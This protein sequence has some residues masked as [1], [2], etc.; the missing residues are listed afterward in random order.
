MARQRDGE[1]S[2]LLIAEPPL[3]VLPSLATLVGLNEAIF[4]QQLHYWLLQSGKDR[5]GRK[6]V[7]NT[8]EEWHEQ[9]PFWSVRTIRRIV[10]GLEEQGLVLSTTAYNAQ[11]VDQTKWYS[12]DYRALDRLTDRADQVDNLA[13]WDGQPDSMQ[14]ANLAASVPETTTETS[15]TREVEHSKLRAVNKENV[16]K[17]DEA[18]LDVLAYVEGY[19][20]EFRDQAPLA[21]SVTRV[22]KLYKA[23]GVD[24]E[25]FVMRM[26]QARAI[27]KERTGQVKTGEGGKKQLMG[28]WFAVLEDLLGQRERETG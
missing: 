24:L 11:K 14:V 1:T 28:Y 12:L 19:A 26:E 25:T 6:W 4:L 17:Y 27:T 23:A 22:T 13:T 8:Y 9:L 10:G 16:D 21:A 20:R 2:K 15:K 7:Y 18:R 5:D 3:L